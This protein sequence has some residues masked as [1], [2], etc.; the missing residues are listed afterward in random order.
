MTTF[1]NTN[2]SNFNYSQSKCQVSARWWCRLGYVLFTYLTTHLASI[3]LRFTIYKYS[4]VSPTKSRHGIAAG[5][6]N[7]PILYSYSGCT[8][9]NVM[10]SSGWSTG[11]WWLARQP[12][13]SCLGRTWSWK[14]TFAKFYNHEDGTSPDWKGWLEK[15]LKAARVLLRDSETSILARVRFQL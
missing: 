14:R 11:S 12:R 8:V 13:A 5:W 4:S 10:F 15:I 7:Q 2:M 9:S 6:Y 3:S 1:D